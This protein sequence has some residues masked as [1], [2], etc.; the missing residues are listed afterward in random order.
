MSCRPTLN[1]LP[2][3][4]DRVYGKNHGSVVQVFPEP[5]PLNEDAYRVFHFEDGNYVTYRRDMFGTWFRN[6]G[7]RKMVPEL[8][9][10]IY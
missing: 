9:T 2:A 7:G 10:R 8:G 4:V 1:D 3:Y 5:N 6:D